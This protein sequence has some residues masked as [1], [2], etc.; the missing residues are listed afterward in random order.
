MR[1][2]EDLGRIALAAQTP[3]HIDHALRAAPRQGTRVG[4]GRTVHRYPAPARDESGDFIRRNRSAALRKAGQQRVDP[5]HQHLAL[6]GLDR[7]GW[8]RQ[9]KRLGL[10]RRRRP[11][12]G[13]LDAAQSKLFARDR[14]AKFVDRGE[15]QTPGQLVQADRGAPQA[16]QFAPEHLPP[17]RHRLLMLDGVEPLPHLGPGTPAG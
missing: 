8:P 10:C 6:A 11:G 4:A 16:L 2:H 7:L 17:R 9:R 13:L 12:Q 15:P 5:H 14:Q 1:Q 3:G